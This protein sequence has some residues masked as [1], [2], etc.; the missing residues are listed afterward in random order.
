MYVPDRDEYGNES[1]MN[2]SRDRVND[3]PQMDYSMGH[4]VDPFVKQMERDRT[5]RD[6]DSDSE[7]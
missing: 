4:I 2:H 6:R 7:D 1:E 3:V 5:L